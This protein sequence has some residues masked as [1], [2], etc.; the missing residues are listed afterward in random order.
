[1]ATQETSFNPG[2]V[3]APPPPSEQAQT[4]GVP[5]FGA[6]QTFN[7]PSVPTAP[8]G[9]G[10]MGSLAPAGPGQAAT[11]TVPS[12][13][14]DSGGGSDIPFGALAGGAGLAALLAAQG[15]DGSGLSFGNILSGAKEFFN[16]GEMADIDILGK[17]PQE[18]QNAV[19]SIM[20][21]PGDLLENIFGGGAEAYSPVQPSTSQ[22]FFPNP[23]LLTDA[24]YYETFGTAGEYLTLASPVAGTPYLQSLP[25]M[26]TLGS[27]TPVATAEALSP[28]LLGGQAEALGAL[29]VASGATTGIGGALSAASAGA[30]GVGGIVSGYA[31]PAALQTGVGGL[32]ST[33]TLTGLMGEAAA[34][35]VAG[36]TP[37]A[38]GLASM[39]AMGPIA[40]AGAAYMAMQAMKQPFDP[41]GP[42]RLSNQIENMLQPGGGELELT[43]KFGAGIEGLE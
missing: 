11:S 6:A 37:V 42:A 9:G 25:S 23:D 19:K 3:Q 4:F 14:S 2:F 31:M 30:T 29:N 43:K 40:L 7:V 12:I 16:L 1:M 26:G 8:M 33:M 13:S 15:D 27:A 28:Y 41:T 38:G 18:L 10:F 34:T 5:S 36:A 22:N 35:T 21:A 20:E 39:G 17:L 32:G 24:E